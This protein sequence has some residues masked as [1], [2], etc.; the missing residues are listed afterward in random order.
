MCVIYFLW[1]F[2][3]FFY[4]I[5]SKILATNIYSI[6]SYS[7]IREEIKFMYVCMYSRTVWESRHICIILVDSQPHYLAEA[8]RFICNR[9]SL[10]GVDCSTTLYFSLLE[11]NNFNTCIMLMIIFVEKE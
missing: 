2:N 5:F 7:K 8:G 6:T 11:N 4:Y 1:Y 10:N 3:V 9:I